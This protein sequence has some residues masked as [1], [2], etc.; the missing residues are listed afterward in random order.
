MI[1]LPNP[2]NSDSAD[3]VMLSADTAVA[4]SPQPDAA[5]GPISESSTSAGGYQEVP[6]APPHAVAG[7]TDCIGEIFHYARLLI[8]EDNPN[9]CAG[10]QNLAFAYEGIDGGARYRCEACGKSVYVPPGATPLSLDV[11]AFMEAIEPPP[12]F[13]QAA[14]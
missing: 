1:S 2:F 8:A 7:A 10:C 11:E 14:Q 3:V 4:S 13:L 9:S 6:A 5:A 12:L